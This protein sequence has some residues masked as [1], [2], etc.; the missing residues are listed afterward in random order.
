MKKFLLLCAYSLLMTPVLAQRTNGAEARY[1]ESRL[2]FTYPPYGLAKVKGLIARLKD[3]K[4]GD[5]RLP[6]KTFDAL[7]F[8]EKFTY[9][10]IHAEDFSQNCAGMPEIAGENKKI[11]GHTPGAFEAD[12][13]TWSERETGFLN[14]NRAKVIRLLRDSMR[15]GHVGINVKGAIEETKAYELIPDLIAAHERD[16][17]DH[18][19]LT[20]M[21]L[22]MDDAK[23]KPFMATT[24]AKKLYGDNSNYQGAIEDT[25]AHE[26]LIVT[27]AGMFAKSHR[28]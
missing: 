8:D 26:K 15:S 24:V 22:L 25:P 2:A 9:V 10:M 19:L 17:D 6:A 28:P 27:L 4:E 3:D 18:D 11:F 23:Y 20:V 21:M 12:E 7:P 13:R 16:P 14:H 5:E 1:H